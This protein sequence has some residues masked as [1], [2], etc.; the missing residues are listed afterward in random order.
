MDIV[1]VLL[2]SGLALL[3]IGLLRGNIQFKEVKIKEIPT[4]PS[5]LLAVMGL[6]AIFGAVY[7]YLSTN[8]IRTPQAESITDI[9]ALETEIA[10]MKA[11]LESSQQE[12]ENLRSDFHSLSDVSDQ[13]KV[14]LELNRLDNS[15]T[16]VQSRMSKIERVIMGDPV[17]A[18]EI[19]LLQKD[20]ES[21][22]A[23][24]DSRLLSVEQS[25]SQIYNLILGVLVVIGLGFLGIAA[26][27]L[28]TARK[29]K[30]ESNSK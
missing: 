22:K 2:F 14:S 1:A 16:D 26:S 20:F 8:T 4:I 9:Q 11:Q 21:T 28:W 3:V 17:Q 13:S 15:I 29:P 6:I 19:P 24:Y 7:L 18:L 30:D 5:V 23:L 10:S 27:N 12:I 25:V